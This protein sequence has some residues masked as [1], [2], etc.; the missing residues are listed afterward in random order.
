ML[1]PTIFLAGCIGVIDE[2][3]VG[4]RTTF[5]KVK[6]EP[7]QPGMYMAILS[8]IRE[9]TT[10]ESSVSI[11]D[12][13]PKTKDNLSLAD[14][15][16][17]IYYTT[18]GD[19]IPGLHVKYIRQSMEDKQS[20]FYP[21]FYLIENIS[22][23]AIYD[24]TSEHDSLTIHQKR[25][26]IAAEIKRRVQESLDASDPGS[27]VISKVVVRQITTDPAIEQS[28]RD[29]V[30]M[31]KLVDTK[32]AELALAQAEAKRVIIEAEGTAKRNAI[33]NASITPNLI[34]YKKANALQDCAQRS[35]CTM[36]VG[37]AT[38]IIGR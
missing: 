1:L 24:V 15:D 5:G 34:E 4:V 35:G 36:I 22:R 18:K 37:N 33:L 9:Y 31:G 30:K 17:A 8:N 3:N 25:D 27:F 10:K 21:G 26:E 16:V 38:P 20:I 7:E 12:M 19:K 11:N 32:N 6:Q 2:G 13:T 29:N 14:M 28:I 23:T